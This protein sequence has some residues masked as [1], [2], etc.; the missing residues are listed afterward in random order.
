MVHPNP[1]SISLT[2]GAHKLLVAIALCSTKVKIDMCN[3]E[4]TPKLIHD[5]AEHH[6]VQPPTHRQQ[7]GLDF[8]EQAFLPDKSGNALNQD[9]FFF[10][11]TYSLMR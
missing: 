9:M 3:L 2:K 1:G 10:R 11:N 4:L 7:Q 6:G 5:F 8:V